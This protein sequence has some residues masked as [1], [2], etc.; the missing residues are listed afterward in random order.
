MLKNRML[1]AVKIDRSLSLNWMGVE[2][3]KR[4]PNN[5]GH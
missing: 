4:K 1:I 2:A 3:V 5:A